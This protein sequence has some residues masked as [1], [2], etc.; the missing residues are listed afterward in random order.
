VRSLE[1]LPH[2]L[3]ESA[4]A[5]V[6]QWVFSPATLAGE[7]VKVYYVLTVNFTIGL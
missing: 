5:A 3:T 7:P 4:M 2:G 1:G 6:R